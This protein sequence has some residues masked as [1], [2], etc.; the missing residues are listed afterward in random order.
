MCEFCVKHGDGKKWYLEAKNYSEDLLS[1]LRRRKFIEHFCSDLDVL[2]IAGER[3]DRFTSYPVFMRWF[4]RWAITRYARI[5]HHGQVIPI[6]DVERIFAMT[7]SIVRLPCICRHITTGTEKRYCYALSMGPRGGKLLEIMTG[8]DTSFL[9]GPDTRGL[10]NLSR[11][12]ALAAVREHELEGLCH[13]VWTFFTPFIGAICN[14]DRTDCLAMKAAVTSEIPIMYRAEYVA[15]VAVDACTGC[16]KCM[17]VCQF[18][19]LSYRAGAKKVSID[20]ARCFGCGICRSVC[21][22]NALQLSPRQTVP[23]AAILW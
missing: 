23:A 22:A 4:F 6:E 15:E 8:L 20:P 7:N 2:R 13:S 10:E 12:A 16:R 3:F 17:Q 21:S 9:R 11:D 19:A 18:G 14:C 5:K 1:D